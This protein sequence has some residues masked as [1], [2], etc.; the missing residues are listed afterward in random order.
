MAAVFLTFNTVFGL[1][2][3]AVAK[4]A[5]AVAKGAA[6]VAKGAVSLVK[7]VAMVK[8]SGISSPS[9]IASPASS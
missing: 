3:V 4:G 9:S 6:A 8:N 7:G 2:G 1:L 5:A